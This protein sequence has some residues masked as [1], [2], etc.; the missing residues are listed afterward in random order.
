[1]PKYSRKDFIIYLRKATGDGSASDKENLARAQAWLSTTI[2]R[3]TIIENE[4]KTIDTSNKTNKAFI[5]KYK[6]ENPEL[7]THIPHAQVIN[8]THANILSDNPHQPVRTKP[9]QKLVATTGQQPLK[10]AGDDEEYFSTLPD[11]VLESLS[12][13]KSLNRMRPDQLL[14]V[15]LIDKILKERSA[16]ELNRISIQ[17]KNGELIPTNEVTL[18]VPMLAKEIMIACQNGVENMITELAKTYSIS[19]ADIAKYRA[20]VNELLNLANANAINTFLQNIENIVEE[21]ADK[22]GR[23]EKK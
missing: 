3:G 18:Y 20:S 22:R 9:A 19:S 12:A 14:K 21:T 6:F 16:T 10:P 15:H 2:K 13:S 17:K 5:E 23:G 1:M 4:D 7:F 11:D 8:E